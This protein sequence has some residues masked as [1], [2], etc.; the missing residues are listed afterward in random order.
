[1][2]DGPKSQTTRVAKS[3]KEEKDKKDKGES[4]ENQAPWWPAFSF[5]GR[6]AMKSKLVLNLRNCQYDLFKTIAIEELGWSVIDNRCN[7]LEP[8]PPSEVAAKSL[9][10]ASGEDE[11]E[12]ST[13][14]NSSAKNQ[15][16]PKSKERRKLEGLQCRLV[17]EHD[18]MNWDIFWAD[19]GMTPEFLSSL[20]TTQRVNHFL[21]MYNICR[22]STLGMHLKRFQKEFPEHYDFFPQT[23]M[24]PAEFHD[25]LEYHKKKTEKRKEKVEEGKMTEA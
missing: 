15:A 7:V 20:S 4:A 9:P 22:K 24:Y 19:S 13:G 8:L 2:A 14:D 23:W 6:N 11:D 18:L 21:G 5:D 1:M 16:E 10:A 12:A 3:K 25:I 17:K